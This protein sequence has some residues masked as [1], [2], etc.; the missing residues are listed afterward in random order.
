MPEA[1]SG[2]D[3]DVGVLMFHNA[4]V[5]PRDKTTSFVVRKKE[6]CQIK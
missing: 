6:V 4:L 3:C 5:S 2:G 1:D